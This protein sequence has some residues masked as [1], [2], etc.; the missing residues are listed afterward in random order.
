MKT[1]NYSRKRE[2]I[3]LKIR[4][5]TC[6][7][8]AEWVFQE[9]K[10]EIP[11]LSLGT[12]YRNISMF[13]ETGM[14]RSIGTVA[15]KERYDGRIETHGHFICQ[16]CCQVSDFEL[17]DE[18]RGLIADIERIKSVVVEKMEL[19]VYGTCETCLTACRLR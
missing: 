3:L 13:K 15:G 17:R 19:S 12:V 8:T 18:S 16:S 4:S 1:K 7:P 9:L 11:D 6:H 2:A 5:T 14:I 10:D